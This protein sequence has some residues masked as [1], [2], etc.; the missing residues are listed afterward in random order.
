MFFTDDEPK[1]NSEEGKQEV[2]LHLKL[3]PN[4]LFAELGISV[5]AKT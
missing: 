4:N 1:I 2:S 5:S 3:V